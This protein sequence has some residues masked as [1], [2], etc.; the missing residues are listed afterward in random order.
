MRTTEGDRRVSCIE[1]AKGVLFMR[2]PR[3]RLAQWRR[4]RVFR[5]AMREFAANPEAALD[6]GSGVLNRLIDGWGNSAHVSKHEF[7]IAA[8][9]GARDARGPILECG[10]GL[11]TVLAGLMAQHHGN[12]LYSLEN[13]PFWAGHVRTVLDAH[14][15]RSV[16]LDVR[17]LKRYGDFDWYDPDF[18]SMPGRFK[19]VLCD[20]PHGQTHGGR[21]GLLPVMREWL[22]PGCTIILDD[23]EREAESEIAGRWARELGTDFHQR[24]R[25]KPYIELRVPEGE[26]SPGE[27]APP[28]AN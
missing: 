18:T 14:G 9:Q 25:E 28:P 22:A 8:L 26:R 23:A 24:G 27:S 5:A 2:E 4:E 19:L 21:Y 1:T 6:P 17:P 12:A 7:L 20:G 10:S 3:R 13:L 16:E 11:S 15:I